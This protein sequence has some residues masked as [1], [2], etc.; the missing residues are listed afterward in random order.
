MFLLR[1][2]HQWALWQAAAAPSSNP[3]SPSWTLSPPFPSPAVP[4][5]LMCTADSSVLGTRARRQA[6]AAAA[7]LH[8]Y[9]LCYSSLSSS[10]RHWS[11]LDL[12]FTPSPLFFFHPSFTLT[13]RSTRRAQPKIWIWS[14]VRCLWRSRLKGPSLDHL[15]D[16]RL[17]LFSCWPCSSSASS[18][19]L[20]AWG[21]N[22]LERL[23]YANSLG[24]SYT[25]CRR[26]RA[27]QNQKA[28][29]APDFAS[30]VTLVQRLTR[31]QV[32]ALTEVA[33]GVTKQIM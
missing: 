6:K 14:S 29:H 21:Y 1:D 9:R 4:E 8:F 11:D 23:I 17:R 20:P 27:G 25:R 2:R 28:R 26:G 15:C 30:L 22:H 24:L 5:G 31:I 32:A 7:P 12:C 18:P 16:H 19:S 10:T 13:P 33:C 3:L